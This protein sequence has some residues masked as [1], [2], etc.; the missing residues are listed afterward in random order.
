M[1]SRF[2]E[3]LRI[4]DAYRMPNATPSG[5][6]T[7]TPN[8][9]S[10]SSTQS[11][12]T[13]KRKRIVLPPA[14][15]D[16]E[17]LLSQNSD[18]DRVRSPPRKRPAVPGSFPGGS[19]QHESSPEPVGDISMEEV[20]AELEIP[21]LTLEAAMEA[22][23]PKVPS[24]EDTIILDID[25]NATED[26]AQ[27][28]VKFFQEQKKQ[29]KVLTVQEAL[30]N[31][32]M[33]E[34]GD[35]LP[36]LD[37]RLLPHQIVGVSWMLNKERHHR[38]MGG[39]LADDMGLGK[40]VQAIALMVL[41]QPDIDDISQRQD[42]RR[43]TLI[44]A[45]A[46]LLD[47]WKDE[48]ET[49][50]D[51]FRV[52]IHH[53]P[54]KAKTAQALRKY[55]VVITSYT[56]MLYD[57]QPRSTRDRRGPLSQNKW[58][59]I[60]LDEA[61]IIRNRTAQ[62]SIACAMLDS[63]YRWLLTGT[64]FTNGL[65]DLYPLLR[66]ARL[67]PWNDWDTFK[68]HIGNKTPK[69]AATATAKMAVIVK[70]HLLRRKKDDM[71][72]GRPLLQLKPKY[73]EMVLVDLSPE[74]RK[75]YDAVE[76][77][78]QQTITRF[79]RAGTLVKN[80][81]FILV[82]IL[83][84]RQVCCHPQLIAYA[85][86]DLAAPNGEHV[87]G[88]PV[89]DGEGGGNRGADDIV[90][91]TSA[92]G[93]ELVKKLKAMLKERARTKLDRA[94]NKLPSPDEDSADECP[95]CTEVMGNS[96]ITVC[97]H[98][99]CNDCIEG[100]FN[101]QIN[102]QG[103]DGTGIAKRPCPLCRTVI[104]EDQLFSSSLFEPTAAEL[105]T[106]MIDIKLAKKKKKKQSQLK[107][108]SDDDLPELDWWQTKPKAGV[109]KEK[110]PKREKSRSFKAANEDL[111][112][113]TLDDDDDLPASP[114]KKR[115]KPDV[116]GKGKAITIDSSSSDSSSDS[117]SGFDDALNP[118]RADMLDQVSDFENSAKMNSMMDLLKQW[119][120]E[121]PDD[122]VVIY[123]Q[124]T[125]CID[126]LEGALER[127]NF[128][129]LRYDGTMDREER[130]SVLKRFKKPGG[131]NI[132]IVS[133]KCGGVGLNLVEANRVICFDPAWNYATESQAYDRVHRIGQQKEVFVNRL[134]AR[135]TIEE[136]ILR[137]QQGKTDLTDAALGEGAGGRIRRLGMG[138]ILGL[139]NMHR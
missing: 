110:K 68:T 130:S 54:K 79:L 80:Y 60:I 128:R 115:I 3:A 42:G 6:N 100:H 34:P 120:E 12:A 101:N 36:G 137:I 121:T 58:Y 84:M 94:I 71:L 62:S 29:P 49:K 48:I 21:G 27:E 20:E 93:P 106:M 87:L 51:M 52:F 75:I 8:A 59:R 50:A 122:K 103:D 109:K 78:Q 33:E 23:R 10:S 129:S 74:E 19:P 77:R 45:P 56:T 116:K 83:R 15:L 105:R 125:K 37:V 72:D 26:Q 136:R 98:R 44:V 43:Q 92:M 82:M 104:R 133:L 108:D 67:R 66:F 113:L 28:V 127:E 88:E 70:K 25:M 13:G 39:I 90:S 123:S 111:V 24:P 132:L 38:E 86:N 118:F 139:F 76:K 1:P 22:S 11:P 53:G 124:W 14:Q 57:V 95:I 131:P 31:L 46:A 73:I 30:E 65:P 5:S 114:S 112:D 4:A 61:Q 89:N 2:E 135:D 18:P 119:R 134:I 99:F 9:A 40:T 91:A 117:D 63:T 81:Q 35:L 102:Y 126:L 32:G 69:D 64:P 138:E 7:P 107:D 96:R 47:Q 17:G 85:A 16:P 55:D 97:G 41:N